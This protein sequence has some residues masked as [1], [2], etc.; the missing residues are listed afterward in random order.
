MNDST[1]LALLAALLLLVLTSGCDIFAGDSTCDDLIGAIAI[2]EPLP[3]TLR[4]TASSA[5]QT[6]VFTDFF[7]LREGYTPSY[8][9]IWGE[10]IVGERS[11]GRLTQA[12][13]EAE[14]PVVSEVS[15]IAED[16]MCS[17][18]TRFIRLP[19]VIE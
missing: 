9:L 1:I 15:I 14:I 11:V 8:R 7:E 16:V 17:G 4:F 3:D 19:I 6:L 5:A 12:R 2:R 10:G 13:F 18:I